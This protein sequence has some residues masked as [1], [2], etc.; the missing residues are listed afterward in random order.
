MLFKTRRFIFYSA[1][2]IAAILVTF[3]TTCIP[4]GP[5]DD[6]DEEITWTDVEYSPDGSITIYLDGSAPV[7]QSRAL[8]YENAKLGHDLFEVAFYHPA[9]NTVAR[10]TWEVGHAA[11]V[12]GVVRNI[13]YASAFS[14]DATLG[15]T[16]G[17]AI[18]FAG[19][20]SD[21]T[22]LGVGKLYEINGVKITSSNAAAII[23]PDTTKVTFKV[24][25]L[26]AGV[27]ESKGNSSFLTAARQND[28]MGS[29]L[30]NVSLNNTEEIIPVMIGRSLFP[31]FR[32]NKEGQSSQS[33]RAKYTFDII[34]D[35]DPD[36]AYTFNDF[37]N[38]ILQQDVADFAM[39][40]PPE[41]HL[42]PRYP[43]GDGTWIYS[44]LL[45]TY[46]NTT[47]VTIENNQSGNVDNPFENGI[48]FNFVTD[49][50]NN[51][52]KIFAFSFE[53]PVY[54][55][56]N[57]DNRKTDGKPWLLRPGYDSYLYDLDDGKGGTGGAILIG[58]GDIEGA[59]S[60]NLRVTRKPQKLVYP[61]TSGSAAGAD[62]AFNIYGIQV[63]LRAG[64]DKVSYVIENLLS[65][66]PENYVNKDVKF[67]FGGPSAAAG[68]SPPGI[69]I[70]DT[71]STQ[72]A[73]DIQVLANANP[74]FITE[75]TV[76]IYVEYSDPNT[77]TFHNPWVTGDDPP[78]TDF[79]EIY[80]SS[81]ASVPD[82]GD[83]PPENRYIIAS[84]LDLTIFGNAVQ[85]N[86]SGSNNFIVVFFDSYDL[87]SIN[88]NG[89]YFFVIIAA[90]PGVTIGGSTATG[91]V[92]NV[93]APNMLDTS[94][95]SFYLGMWPFNETLVVNGVAI[96]SHRFTIRPGSG[97]FING[98]NK[99]V[100]VGPGLTVDL[101][102][103]YN[104]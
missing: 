6:Y 3:I 18:I 97:Y 15:T 60:Y 54:P 83:F 39:L 27:G 99:V 33:V 9:S 69:R 34:E 30:T 40:S 64:N 68:G 95:S 35:T 52:G 103:L 49:Y 45:N 58:T 79:F 78:Y 98:N 104:P 48:E 96:N 11:G 4:F 24:A 102:H 88:I 51:N 47:G 72:P 53:I 23:R 20:K 46:E 77:Q 50:T 92:F 62:D 22:L 66:P 61:N 91:N 81:V 55:L 76:K 71:T 85:N 21:R 7:R 65:I 56:T 2:V 93:T 101:A 67:Y 26:E 84:E 28:G 25:P 94:T 100:H 80:L 42:T 17:A 13:D 14:H 87:G 90:K 38:G 70:F 5:P 31:L 1:A 36:T 74:G 37:H 19:K 12:S 75:G 29:S 59:L 43:A 44:S 16:Q 57:Y 8:N 41:M 86:T 82:S 73:A 10:A 89:Q 32:L 63:N